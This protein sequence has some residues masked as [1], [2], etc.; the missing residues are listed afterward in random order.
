MA[1]ILTI[2]TDCVTCKSLLIEGRIPDAI[3]SVE[4]VRCFR[5]GSQSAPERL[6]ASFPSVLRPRRGVLPLHWYGEKSEQRSLEAHARKHGLELSQG[7]HSSWREPR[8]SAG[9]RARPDTARSRARGAGSWQLELALRGTW[10]ACAFRRFASLFCA[11]DLVRKP[12]TTFRDHACR[13][14]VYF[15]CVLKV[16]LGR[17]ASREGFAMSPLPGFEVRR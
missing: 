15:W 1:T 10:L 17:N 11:H 3:R 13:G 9:R 4:R 5:A 2:V 16:E 6:R 14:R 7:C 8:R 12:D